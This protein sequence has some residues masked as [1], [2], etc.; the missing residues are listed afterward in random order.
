MPPGS[1]AQNVYRIT[2]TKLS[3]KDIKELKVTGSKNGSGMAEFIIN[4]IPDCISFTEGF[5]GRGIVSKILENSGA[6]V[7]NIWCLEI[8]PETFH[9]QNTDDYSIRFILTDA[10]EWINAMIDCGEIDCNDCFYFDPPY[11]MES[12]SHKRKYYGKFDWEDSEHQR[13]FCIGRETTK[14]R[15]FCANKPLPRSG[16]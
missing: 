5:G 9:S 14:N 4:H 16:V 1:T 3:M 2:Q 7:G 13:F 6:S 10:I 12:R 11:R 8:N 15:G